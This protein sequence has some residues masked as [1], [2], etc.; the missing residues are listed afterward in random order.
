MRLFTTQGRAERAKLLAFNEQLRK[1]QKPFALPGGDGY[2]Q[3]FMPEL[4]YYYWI[5][6]NPDLRA[7][8][9]EIRKKAWSKFLRSDDGRKYTVNPNE[10]RKLPNSGIIVR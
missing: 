6:R 4:D 9:P 3:F 1:E 8:D 7:G 2:L 5:W 10:G